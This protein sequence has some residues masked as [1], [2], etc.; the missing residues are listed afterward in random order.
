MTARGFNT[1]ANAHISMKPGEHFV[2]AGGQTKDK[3]KMSFKKSTTSA[4]NAAVQPSMSLDTIVSGLLD[5]KERVKEAK[6]DEERLRERLLTY[7]TTNGRWINKNLKIGFKEIEYE[8]SPGFDYAGFKT[9]APDLYAKLVVETIV[10]EL[11]QEAVE[12]AIEEN[13][14]VLGVLQNYVLPGTMV[15]KLVQVKEDDK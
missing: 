3:S 13:P 4:Q 8:R 14:V 15:K 6:A 2:V 11:N 10:P 9:W 12:A 7:P 5:A 1:V